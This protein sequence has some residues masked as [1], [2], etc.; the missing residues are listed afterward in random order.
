ML[1]ADPINITSLTLASK[2]S[3][4]AGTPV[5]VGMHKLRQALTIPTTHIITHLMK[6]AS[7]HI[8]PVKC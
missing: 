4:A 1:K 2:F 3:I 8:I 5:T 6:P 7:V